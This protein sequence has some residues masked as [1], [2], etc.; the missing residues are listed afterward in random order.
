MKRIKWFN[1]NNVFYS[2]LLSETDARKFK[3]L[4][5]KRYKDYTFI[6]VNNIWE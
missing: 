2:D 1:D 5:K 4:C 6:L 3:E